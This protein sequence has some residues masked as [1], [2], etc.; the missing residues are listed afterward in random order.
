LARIQGGSSSITYRATRTSTSAGPEKVVLKV[1]PAGL[2]PVKNRDVL[3][4]ARIQRVLRDT[5]VPCPR[6]LA[7]HPGSP[8]E[9]PPFYVMTFEDG[10]CVEPNSLP[11]TEALPPDEVRQR[12]LDAARI[13]GVLH[14]LEPEAL[15]LRDE[16]EVT[17]VQE[18][19]RWSQS[20]AACDED[21]RP[22]YE[23]VRDRLAA[24]V[25]PRDR[26]SLIHGDFRLGN[27]L[28]AG[29]RVVS[30]IDWEIWGRSDPRVDVAWYLMMCNPDP[31]LG[32]RTSAGMPGNEELLDVYQRARGADVEDMSWFN[33]LV[34]YKQAAIVALI[35]RNARRRGESSAMSGTGHLLGSAN[36]LLA[37]A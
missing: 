35:M 7:E 15:G 25:P 24:A 20:L 9:V 13:L 12:E 37:P 36:K 1:A 28:S 22:G 29:T 27:T 6:V 19:E 23:E 4:Q 11:E 3:R 17:P 34:R 5:G 10:D 16:P 14:A 31:E 33:A 21:L 18:L 32:R 8:P 2:D 26:S 30:V